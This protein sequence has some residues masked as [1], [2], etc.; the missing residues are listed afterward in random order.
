VTYDRTHFPA[1]LDVVNAMLA[2]GGEVWFGDAGRGPAEE[3]VRRALE[4]GWLVSRFDANDQPLT[5]FVLGRFQRIVLKR[6]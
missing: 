4:R 1:L 5:D 6:A 3:F 2:T